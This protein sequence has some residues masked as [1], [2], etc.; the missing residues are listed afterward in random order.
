MTLGFLPVLAWLAVATGDEAKAGDG[1]E[2]RFTPPP[3]VPPGPALPFIEAD[4]GTDV[5][6]RNCCALGA[7]GAV[8]FPD[9]GF[10]KYRKGRPNATLLERQGEDGGKHGYLYT[11][12]G[13]FIDLG[14]VRDNIDYARFFAAR[15]YNAP[16]SGRTG[17]MSFVYNEGADIHLEIAPR[18]ERPRPELAA[19]MGA[20]LA[21]ERALWHEII[22]FFPPASTIDIDEQ[23]SSFAP[24]DLFSNAVGVLAGYRAILTPDTP[25]DLTAQQH[26]HRIIAR[27]GP[28]HRADETTAAIALVKDHWWTSATF[29][30]VKRRNFDAFSP[31]RPWLLTDIVIDGKEA[32]G[33][34]LRAALARPKPASIIIPA[35]HAG[36]PLDALAH[37]EFRNLPASLSALVPS[38][39]IIRG[40]DLPAVVAAIRAKARTIHGNDVDSPGRPAP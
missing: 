7:N 4:V 40:S 17:A 11:R 22:T 31:V 18:T 39:S 25:F 3:K 38:L 33:D 9:L 10:H 8:D 37:F 1:L 35:E 26:L 14:H 27:L 15:Y 29:P 2:F 24:E 32:E 23:F 30:P 28:V 36:R 21:Y 19:A 6:G 34:A 13:G 5:L 12:H 16:L 20:K